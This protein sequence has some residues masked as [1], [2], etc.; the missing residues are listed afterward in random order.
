MTANE[1]RENYLKA[2]NTLLSLIE[3][4][5]R[6]ISVAEKYNSSLEIKQYRHLRK[7]YLQQL[8]DMMERMPDSMKLEVI[9]HI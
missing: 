8:S 7:D 5:N 2:L 3:G 9:E 1:H 6:S 4:A